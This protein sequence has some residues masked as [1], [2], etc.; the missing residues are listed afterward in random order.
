MNVGQRVL[1]VLDV[2]CVGF[3]DIFGLEWSGVELI[4]KQD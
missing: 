3:S 4:P 1:D 2:Q